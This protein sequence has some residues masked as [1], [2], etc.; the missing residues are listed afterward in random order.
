LLFQRS[1][2][3]FA[4]KDGVYHT[5][6]RVIKMRAAFYRQNH[7]T[8]DGGNK[9]NDVN[10][11]LPDIKPGMVIPVGSRMAMSPHGPA[12]LG[13]KIPA[14]VPMRR[15]QYIDRGMLFRVT[16]IAARTEK[17]NRCS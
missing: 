12:R 10:G 3:F 16:G 1:R 2:L 6:D 17:G 13:V 15:K 11:A 7:P 9:N 14:T 5:L 8:R 4:V